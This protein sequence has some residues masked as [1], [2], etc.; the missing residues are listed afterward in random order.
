MNLEID[1]EYQAHH[2]FEQLKRYSDF[3]SSLS[4]STMGFVTMG[5]TGIVNMDTY[6]FSSMQG[7]LESIRSILLLGRIN[8]SYA[9]LR[10]FYDSTV[11]NVYTNIYLKQEF[12]LD[13]FVVE[14][15]ENWRKGTEKMPRFGQISKYIGNSPE[16]KSVTELVNKQGNYE[17][18]RDRCNDHTHYNFYHN[19]LIND[20]EIP[21]PERTKFLDR[22]S[23]DLRDILIQHLAYLFYLNAHYMTSSDYMD[24]KDLGLEPP[25]NS[26]YFVAPFIQN[27]MNDVV[28]KNRPDI[29]ELLKKNTEMEL[30]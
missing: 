14:Q 13:S 18:I 20:N 26:E 27:I 5:T 15:I 11:I 28:R 22:F 3:Y 10:K 7:T 6:V 8:D 17:K 24:H 30:D 25:E 29:Y 12:S 9:L 2:V 16:L 1:K 4:F 21:L 19:I 23:T